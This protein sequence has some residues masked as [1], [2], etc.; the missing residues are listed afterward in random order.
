MQF[1]DAALTYLDAHSVPSGGDWALGRIAAVH[2]QGTRGVVFDSNTFE[3][4]D[5]NAMLVEG[6]SRD[7]TIQV[8]GER[9]V[10]ERAKIKWGKMGKKERRDERG[11]EMREK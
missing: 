3:R 6:Y 4:L 2:V 10:E 7:L 9:R 5:G 1:R 11:E 8:L